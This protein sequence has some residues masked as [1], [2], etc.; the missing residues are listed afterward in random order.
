KLQFTEDYI[1]ILKKT[2]REKE[3]NEAKYRQNLHEIKELFKEA[4]PKF[5]KLLTY[6]REMKVFRERSKKAGLLVERL[7]RKNFALRQ[8]VREL[9]ENKNG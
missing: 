3:D 5:S 7:E 6:K 1:K 4:S 9:K 8:K 2:L